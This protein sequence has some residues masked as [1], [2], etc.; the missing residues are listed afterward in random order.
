MKNT[1]MARRQ[2]QGTAIRALFFSDLHLKKANTWFKNG[3]ELQYQAIRRAF[4]YAVD[5][6]IETVVIGGDISEDHYLDGGALGVLIDLLCEFDGLLDIHIILGNHDV[7]SEEHHSLLP[8]SRLIKGRRFKSVNVYETPTFR[9]LNGVPFNFLP[10]PHGAEARKRI[11]KPAIN[12][13]HLEWRGAVRDNGVSTIGT[14]GYFHKSD[15]L[16]WIGHLHTPQSLQNGRITYCGT[17]YQCSFGEQMEKSMCLMEGTAEDLKVTRIP[18]TLPWRLFNIK[19]RHQRDLGR[20][21]MELTDLVKLTIGPDIVLPKELPFNIIKVIGNSKPIPDQPQEVQ[22][23]ADPSILLKKL[24]FSRLRSERKVV[25]TEMK[26]ILQDVGF[27]QLAA[28]IGA[29]DEATLEVVSG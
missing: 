5:H 28:R 19:V 12:V 26:R 20:L 23:L 11:K 3:L 29:V 14:D 4:Q 1:M 6:G 13:A 24:L 27:G 9:H 10:F 21:P 17:L 18:V 16:W 7:A 15:D 25:R 2:S 22:G 8:V